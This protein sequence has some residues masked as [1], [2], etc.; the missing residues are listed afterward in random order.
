MIYLPVIGAFIEAVGMVLEKRILKKRIMN[1]KN[2]NFQ[3]FLFVVILMIPVILLYKNYFLNIDKQAFQPINLIILAL[4]ILF[5]FFANLLIFYSLKR[6][7]L[8]ELEPI[9]LM[10]PLFTIL[11][12]F[13]FSFFFEAFYHERNYYILGLGLIASIALVFSHIKKNHLCFDK[14]IIAALFGGMFFSIEL[15]LSN[16]ILPY[17]N[18]FTFYFIRCL[19]IFILLAI[20]FYKDIKYTDNKTTFFT[21]VASMTWI[22]FR[23]ITYYGY[24]K[25]G[26]VHTTVIFILTPIFIYFMAVIFLKEKLRIKNIIS[27]IIIL[28]CVI[29]AFF[30]K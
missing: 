16:F 23:I 20:I 10:Q 2:F 17:Y 15:V 11:F 7:C 6:E 21:I 8:T 9:A 24:E 13:I 14:Y 27:A 19:G 4:I 1:F 22:I 18:S 26:I 5:S 12:A 30:L 28:A 3:A 25:L 29:A